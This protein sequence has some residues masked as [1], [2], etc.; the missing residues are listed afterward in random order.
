MYLTVIIES[1]ISSTAVS[2]RYV[3]EQVFDRVTRQTN[4]LGQILDE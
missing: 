3:T 2:E 4:N 1:P